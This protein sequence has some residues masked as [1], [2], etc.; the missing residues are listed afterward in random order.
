MTWSW[1]FS[2]V[3]AGGDVSQLT[4]IDGFDMWGAIS[5]DLPSPRTR[6]LVNIDGRSGYSALRFGR[7]KYVNGECW[8]TCWKTGIWNTDV[9]FSAGEETAR[10]K[11]ALYKAT[12]W[13]QSWLFSVLY[14]KCRLGTKIPRY[15][16]SFSLFLTNVK[17]KKYDQPQSLPTSFTLL[18][19]HWNVHGPSLHLLH[20]P[21]FYIATNLHPLTVGWAETF[22]QY[23]QPK[24]FFHFLR[25]CH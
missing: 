19:N 12:R 16:A 7:Y 11:A 10:Q 25:V 23:S 21:K 9:M 24:I 17:A 15:A 2:V 5:H 4:G 13:R 20:Y 8:K 3:F 6:L 22:W 14:S 1:P 18:N